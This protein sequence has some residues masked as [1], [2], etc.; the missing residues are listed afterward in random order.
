MNKSTLKKLKT[1][2]KEFI[3]FYFKNSFPCFS[4]SVL[5]RQKCKIALKEAMG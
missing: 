4:L 3:A 2:S 5:E 1:I